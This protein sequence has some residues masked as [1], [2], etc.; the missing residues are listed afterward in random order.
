MSKLVPHF[1]GRLDLP[2]DVLLQESS[3]KKHFGLNT[4]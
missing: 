1:A 2:V 3:S 4:R